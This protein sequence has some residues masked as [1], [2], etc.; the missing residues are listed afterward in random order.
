MKIGFYDD[1][2]PCLVQEDGVLDI[3]GVVDN[4]P[5]G[6]PSSFLR[7]SS[8]IDSPAAS[9]GAVAQREAGTRKC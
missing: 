7:A 4:H 1:Y 9:Y 3:S 5:A 8:P 6:L 2:R